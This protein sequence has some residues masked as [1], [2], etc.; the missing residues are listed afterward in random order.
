MDR[1]VGADAPAL[2][3]RPTIGTTMKNI[4]STLLFFGVGTIV[5]NLM[6]YEFI[7]LA[8]IDMWGETVGWAIRGAMIVAGGILFFLGWRAEQGAAQPAE[9]ERQTPSFQASAG[10]QAAP[11]AGPDPMRPSQ[12]P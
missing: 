7:I 9:A 11:D 5:L 12:N 6:G 4:G 1:V 3:S 2:Y 10:G 8:W